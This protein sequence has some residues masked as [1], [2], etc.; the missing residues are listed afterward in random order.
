MPLV[1]CL[2]YLTAYRDDHI[3]YHLSS[4]YHV[5][6]AFAGARALRLCT[7]LCSILTASP[8]PGVIIRAIAGEEVRF[9]PGTIHQLCPLTRLSPPQQP[10]WHMPTCAPSRMDFCLKPKPGCSTR[11][12]PPSLCLFL[13]QCWTVTLTCT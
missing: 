5:L 8:W 10:V 7:L 9:S 6:K 3:D 4:R 2:L 13:L 11:L 12:S 1:P